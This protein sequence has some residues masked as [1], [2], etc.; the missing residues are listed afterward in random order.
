MVQ[1][2][3][4]LLVWQK[5]MDLADTVYS[6]T[7]EFPR[8]EMFGPTSQIKRAAVSIPS[9]IAEG[10]AIGGGRF[11]WH[12]R[13]ALG[14]G[15]ELQTQIELAIRRS[16]VTAERAKEA[17]DQAAEV[18][19]MLHAMHRA[20]KRRQTKARTAAIVMVILAMHAAGFLPFGT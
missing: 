1:S 18:A 5:A 17:L 19:R 8:S 3:R 15:A 10:R 11:L 7:T 2:F 9:N 6:V 14:S 12:I 4:D 13:V 16:Y 20:L